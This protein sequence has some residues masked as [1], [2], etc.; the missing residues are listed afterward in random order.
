IN[1][2]FSDFSITQLGKNKDVIGIDTFLDKTKFVIDEELDLSKSLL[3]I[4]CSDGTFVETKLD[5]SMISGFNT[6]T[7][8]IKTLNISY[9]DFV[10][11]IEYEV[12]KIDPI[13]TEPDMIVVEYTEGLR[14]SDLELPAGFS[15][16]NSDL[17]L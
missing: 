9:N 3:L 12:E 6:L 13:F 17:I 4:Y 14:L 11:E 2:R 5:E 10:E 16:E 8:G 1:L 15:W 7:S